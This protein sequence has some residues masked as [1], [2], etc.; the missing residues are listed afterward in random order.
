MVPSRKDSC[1]P[2]C[3]DKNKF[4]EFDRFL[5]FSTTS[6]EKEILK[7]FQSLRSEKGK[8]LIKE[9]SEKTRSE[10]E[11]KRLQFSINY[12]RGNN[13]EAKAPCVGGEKRGLSMTLK[14]VSWN[15]RGVNDSSKRKIIKALLRS[16][17]L[18]LFCLQET[19][20]CSMSSG[21]IKTLGSGIS[22]D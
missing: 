4:E 1:N 13:Y 8:T 3:R 14:I 18:D 6:M 5:G 11:L 21:A 17:R 2:D 10:R 19:K 20:M 7:F 16:R 12:K 9:S 22:L 15:V